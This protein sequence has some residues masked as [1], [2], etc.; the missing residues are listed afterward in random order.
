MLRYSNGAWVL[1]D[2][3]SVMDKPALYEGTNAVLMG[4]ETMRKYIPPAYRAPEA[5][6]P[7]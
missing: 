6:L 7:G 4:K 3:G 2:F 1:C 5:R